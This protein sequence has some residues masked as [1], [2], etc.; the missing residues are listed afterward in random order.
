MYRQEFETKGTSYLCTKC[1]DWFPV[2]IEIGRLD[3][4]GH[5][6]QIIQGSNLF[7]TDICVECFVDLTTKTVQAVA[8]EKPF[9]N[10]TR[11]SAEDRA[12]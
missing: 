1:N 4:K 6:K 10:P 12:S 9:S 8:N 11:N 7:T 2:V 3:Y 5:K